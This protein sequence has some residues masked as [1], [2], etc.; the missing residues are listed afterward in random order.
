MLF[1][2]TCGFI[3]I[4]FKIELS[5]YSIWRIESPLS[6]G[7]ILILIG[8]NENFY[9]DQSPQIRKFKKET[10]TLHTCLKKSAKTQKTISKDSGHLK[11]IKYSWTPLKNMVWKIKYLYF[12]EQKSGALLLSIYLE[13]QENNAEK[14]I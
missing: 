3:D 5:N 6:I 9:L 12:Q 11:K 1:Q 13:D 4:H 10:P 14:D 8:L 2:R 7:Q